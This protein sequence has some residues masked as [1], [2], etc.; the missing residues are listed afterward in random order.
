MRALIN[1]KDYEGIRNA[2][3]QNPSLAN[4]GISF[5]EKNTVKTHPLHR[6]CDGV[7]AHA[8]TNKEAVEIARI[9]LAYGANINGYELI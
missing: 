1:S 3:S 5:D 4:E 9:F 8:Y 2:L 7:F 6:I